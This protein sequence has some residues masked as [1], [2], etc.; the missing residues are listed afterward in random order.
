MLRL[1]PEAAV[2]LRRVLPA[3]DKAIGH[4]L[5]RV[6]RA[7][8]DEVRGLKLG[9]VNETAD[10]DQV[11]ARHGVYLSVDRHVAH[12]LGDKLI[13]VTPDGGSVYIRSA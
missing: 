10:G 9:F 6:S 13:D 3:T 11:S 8:P 7:E 1:T 4:Y 2:Y 12:E 5:L